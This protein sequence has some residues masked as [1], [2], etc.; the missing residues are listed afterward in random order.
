MSMFEEPTQES[1]DAIQQ[2][3]LERYELDCKRLEIMQDIPL[4]RLRE[5]AS[6]EREGRLVVVPCRIGDRI[7]LPRGRIRTDQSGVEWESCSLKAD[8]LT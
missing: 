8:G 7:Y 5:L 2:E 6:A 4:D 1:L 3:A